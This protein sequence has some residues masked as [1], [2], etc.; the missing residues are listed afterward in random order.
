MHPYEISR[1]NPWGLQSQL[2]LLWLLSL[3]PCFCRVPA[4]A[5]CDV[6][7]SKIRRFCTALRCDS[8]VWWSAGRLLCARIE[9]LLRRG[10][11][12][13]PLWR[14]GERRS[15]AGRE[16]AAEVARQVGRH[17]WSGVASTTS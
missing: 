13:V 12:I 14:R 2:N 4:P 17:V 16:V 10:T 15:I 5:R 6:L 9:R 1:H 7:G 8:D 3:T 11:R